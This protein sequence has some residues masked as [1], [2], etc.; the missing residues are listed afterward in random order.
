MEATPNG[1]A[2][3]WRHRIEAQR[4]SGQ[5]VRAWCQANGAAEHSFFWWRAK[6]GLSRVKRRRRSLKPRTA[7]SSPLAFAQV[8]VN[9]AASEPLRVR[10]AG[11]QRELI[12]PA[13]MPIE[14]VAKLVHAIEAEPSIMGATA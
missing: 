4:A 1:K 13:S 2:E 6:L 10:L 8:L 11:Q 12:L 9:A 7:K 5:S 3:D 14:Q